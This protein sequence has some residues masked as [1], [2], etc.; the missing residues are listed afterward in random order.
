MIIIN[1]V[2]KEASSTVMGGD[3]C[4][5]SFYAAEERNLCWTLPRD[6]VS[7]VQAWAI[8]EVLICVAQAGRNGSSSLIHQQLT[9]PM[10]EMNVTADG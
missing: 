3:I 9:K 8:I 1:L 6:K 10:N 2:F 4:S 5:F 7:Y